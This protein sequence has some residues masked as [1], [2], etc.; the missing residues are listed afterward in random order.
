MSPTFDTGAPASV[1]YEIGNPVTLYVTV[2]VNLSA[3]VVT[4]AVVLAPSLKVTTSYGFTKS[5]AVPLFCKCQPAFI[6]SLTV[7]A[8]L[9][10][11]SVIVG[12]CTV[13]PSEFGK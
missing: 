3:D 13:G 6:T 9:P 12:F 8:C 5:L 1:V 10:T 11:S 7:A 4:I 2:L